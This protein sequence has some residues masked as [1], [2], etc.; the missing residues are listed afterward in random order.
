MQNK[1]PIVYH[2]N[3]NIKVEEFL[4]SHPFDAAKYGKVFDYLCREG[5]LDGSNHHEVEEIS[6]AALLKV[7]SPGYLK[8][9]EL[10]HVIAGVAEL[11]LL[12]H[13]ALDFLKQELLRPLRHAVAGSVKAA[14]LALAEGWAINLGGGFHHA[15]H[16]FAHGFCFYA[17]I[18]LAAESIW[19]TDPSK[20]IMVIDLDAHQGNGFE[21]IFRDD[22]RVR[23]F[24]MYNKDNFPW[25]YDAA[26]FIHH[27]YPLEPQTDTETYLDILQRELPAA[28]DVDCPEL[29]IYNAGVDIY[30][31]DPLGQL[32][33]SREGIAIRDLLVFQMARERQ[34]PIVMLLS[35][36]YTRESW[37]LIGESISGLIRALDLAPGMGSEAEA[38][39]QPV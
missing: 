16:D 9:L 25:D 3:Y 29:I 28:L 1:L 7:H 36:G 24:D 20:C 14:H 27:K 4:G 37:Q 15:K 18:N 10:A 32:Q 5:I 19:E 11:P 2:P 30:R 34:I 26:A 23:M 39:D 31:E 21:A 13:L 33:V 38:G 35:G 8:S 6:D 17:D 12:A 22:P